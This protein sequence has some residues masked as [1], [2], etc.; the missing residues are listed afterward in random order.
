MDLSGCTDLRDLAP[1]LKRLTCVGCLDA[2]QLFT[3][4]NDAINLIISAVEDLYY[5]P[6]ARAIVA[7]EF[8]DA[9]IACHHA[10]D[11]VLVGDVL[12]LGDSPD[13]MV[14]TVR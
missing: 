10:V 3:D 13:V 8:Y 7:T 9:L 11:V 5:A 14:D 1:N 2:T 4:A 12:S 6:S